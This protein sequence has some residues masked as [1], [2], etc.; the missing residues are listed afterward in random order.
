MIYESSQVAFVCPGYVDRI[1]VDEVAAWL[2]ALPTT[3]FG[4]HQKQPCVCVFF[5][6]VELHAKCYT[7]IYATRTLKSAFQ[8]YFT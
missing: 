3:V 2:T 5:S 7:T 1:A 6:T 8:T 4:Q